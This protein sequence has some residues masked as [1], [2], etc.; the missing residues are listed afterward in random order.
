MSKSASILFIRRFSH[1]KILLGCWVFL[2][3][4]CAEAQKPSPSP[5]LY[6]PPSGSSTWEN[7]PLE[8][9]DW[10]R[11]ALAELLA[12]LPTQDTRAFIILKN[13]KIVVEEYWGAKLTGAGAMDQNSY[14]YWASAGKTLTAALVGIAQEKSMLKTSDRSQQYLGEG[15][16]AMPLDQERDIQLIHHL[17]LTTGI[18]DD[19]ENLDDPAPENLKFL[20]KP[21]TRWS[22]HN[23]TYTLLERV[24]ENA[25]GKDYQSFFEESLGDRIGMDGFWQQ[26]GFNNVFYSTPRS[27]AR[28]GLLMLAGG[29]WAGD[30]IWSGDYF[31]GMS[32]TSQGLNLSY[33]YLTW[34]NGKASF[35]V[36]GSQATIPGSLIPQAP[37]DMYQAMGKN[38]QFLMVIPSE[39][40]VIVRMG[41]SGGDALVPFLL[42]RDIWQHLDQVIH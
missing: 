39:N 29:N 31:D 38:G 33:G 41:S 10:D 22:Y 36:P 25:S 4:G 20:A 37:A 17:T 19:V 42:M 23:A 1:C 30:Q 8:D 7:M 24:V 35:M 32:Q 5:T 15:W 3:F 40:L 2:A 21:G 18:D 6:F 13:G 12:W 14:W 9:L 16:T 11:A 27:F 34:L 26:T 28:F